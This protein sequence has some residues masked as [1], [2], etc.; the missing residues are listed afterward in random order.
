MSTLLPCD[1][2]STPTPGQ[3]EHSI[4]RAQGGTDHTANIAHACSRCNGEKADRTVE[5]WAADRDRVGLSWPPIGSPTFSDGLLDAMTPEQFN[6]IDTAWILYGDDMAKAFLELY[7]IARKVPTF[8]FTK[9]AADMVA[10]AW[11][12]DAVTV[13]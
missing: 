11:K 9:A 5:E 7:A 8:T 3:V 10:A 1:Y 12:A 2:C 6:L 4:P 13:A